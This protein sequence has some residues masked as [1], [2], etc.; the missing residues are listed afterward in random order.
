MRDAIEI[1]VVDDNPIFREAILTIL[2]RNGYN[3]L[4]FYES[5]EKLIAGISSDSHCII[6][7]DVEMPGLDG[8]QT[9]GCLKSTGPNTR[10]IAM[11]MYDHTVHIE[12]LKKSGFLGMVLKYRIFDDLANIIE[13]VVNNQPAFPSNRN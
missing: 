9:A 3:Q 6:L 5:G 10:P 2:K 8:I 1:V 13:K 12:T 11:T 4:S 7:M